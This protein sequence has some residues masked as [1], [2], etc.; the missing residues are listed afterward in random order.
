MLRLYAEAY[1]FRF[2]LPAMTVVA[3]LTIRAVLLGRF[4]SPTVRLAS[5]VFSR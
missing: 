4:S 3:R 2:S 1:A 5:P